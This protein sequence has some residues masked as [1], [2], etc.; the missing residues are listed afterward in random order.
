[1]HSVGLISL[2]DKAWIEKGFWSHESWGVDLDGLS[3]W[4]LVVLGDLRAVLG[5]TLVGFS[6]KRDET[7]TLLKGNDDLLPCGFSTLF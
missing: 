4:E 3:I 6:V 7:K 5:L 1:M 2:L